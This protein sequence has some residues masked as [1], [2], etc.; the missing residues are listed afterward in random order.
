MH[1]VYF[2]KDR[3]DDEPVREY[4]QEL[5]EKSDKASRIQLNKIQ[6]YIEI[7]EKNGVSAGAPYMKHLE[8]DIWE[9]RPR[10]DRILF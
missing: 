5:S 9:L 3:N 6:D 1:K 4:I 10:K 2:Y 7:L 8:G